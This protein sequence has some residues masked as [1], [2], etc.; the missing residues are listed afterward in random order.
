M[1]PII[2][3]WKRVGRV[4]LG[5][6]HI[7]GR[8]LHIVF[9]CFLGWITYLTTVTI[10][11]VCIPIDFLV[12]KTRLLYETY[13]CFSITYVWYGNMQVYLFIAKVWCNDGKSSDEFPW[14]FSFNWSLLVTLHVTWKSFITLKLATKFS[15]KNIFLKLN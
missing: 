13:K 8:D 1:F 2:L 14:A 5:S 10:Y 12:W 3:S 7:V 11:D 15:L 9:H 6:L 4:R